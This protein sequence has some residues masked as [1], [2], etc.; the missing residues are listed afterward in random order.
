MKAVIKKSPGYGAKLLDI[1]TPK[2][3]SNDVLIK[4][5]AT[6]ICGTDLHIYEWNHWAQN[7]IKTP[8]VLGHELCGEVVEKGENVSNVEVGEFVSAETHIT[9]GKCY[10]CLNN[11]AHICRDMRILGVDVDGCFSEYVAVPSSCVWKNDKALKPEWASVQEPFG[12]SVHALFAEDESVEGKSI[13][14]FGCGP[15]GLF[16]TAIAKASNAKFVV[17]SDIN[18]YRLELAKKIGADYVFNPRKQNV[19]NQINDLT[20]GDRVDIV[21]EMSGSPAAFKNA[22]KSLRR[23][24]RMS[25]FGLYD[26]KIRVNLTDDVIFQGTKIIGITGR[27]IWDTWEKTKELLNSKR[28]DIDPIITHKFKLEEFEKGMEL[29]KQGLCGKIILYP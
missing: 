18:D 19:V 25:L 29:M 11:Q 8:L 21:L 20:K 10:Q 15:I 7:R 28:I 12:N 24:G 5:K 4:V 2:I 14:V 27:K 9:C 23:G 22:S 13:A 16:A 6:S 1:D 3:S 26:Q 17:A